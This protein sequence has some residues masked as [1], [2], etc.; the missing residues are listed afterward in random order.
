PERALALPYGQRV[1]RL[2]GPPAFIAGAAWTVILCSGR[3][4]IGAEAEAFIGECDLSVR[5]S[6]AGGDAVAK[7]GDE[8]VAHRDF[9]GN[10][11]AAVRSARD[12]DGRNGGAA[13][14][15]PEIDRL[16]AIEGG[17]LRTVAIVERPGAGGADRHR[18]G[19]PEDHGMIG[20]RQ[21]AFLHIVA[22]AGLADAPG[23]VDAEPVD[24]VARPAAAVALHFQ[25]LFRGQDAATAGAVGVQEEIPLFAKQAEAVANL[26]RNLER[27]GRLRFRPCGG[28]R[29]H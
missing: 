15:R 28:S 16:G 14:A 29:N 4:E 24:D 23:E 11:L 8:D 21:V 18:P 20:R 17:C 3:A 10:A 22:G 9:G 25:R 6:F 5:I 1:R 2:A 7:A 26:P 13:I 27:R 12:V 19:Q